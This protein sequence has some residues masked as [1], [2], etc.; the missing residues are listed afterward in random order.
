MNIEAPKVDL[1][2]EKSVR[3]YLESHFRYDTMSSHNRSTSFAQNIKLH[4]LKLEADPRIQ[5][6]DT[7]SG[8][9]T[10]MDT[11]YSLLEVEDIWEQFA[12]KPIAKYTA[13]MDYQYTIG[14]NGRSGGYLVMYNSFRKESEHK[15]YC[16]S[17]GQR[18]F[19]KV[20]DL[21]VNPLGNKC[22]RCGAV[23]DKGRVDYAKPLMLL[24]TWPVRSV[25]EDLEYLSFEN[26]KYL[27]RAVI[28]FDKTCIEIRENFIKLI[29]SSVVEEDV[30]M[31]PK[32]VKV[33]SSRPS[34]SA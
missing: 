19:T 31:V 1:R 3:E 6:L 27:A 33:L 7:A 15:S 13:A 20:Q 23:G 16:R 18:N 9:G 5:A 11:A 22:G 30:V 34:Q 2:S 21:A 12:S 32:T 29:L 4:K 10:G 28:A 14:S 26:L 17:C 8:R 24:Q 25:G